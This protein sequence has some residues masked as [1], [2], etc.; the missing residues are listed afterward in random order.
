MRGWAH[1]GV[2]HSGAADR[3]AYAL[4]NRLVGNP[5]GA[6]ALECTFG[7]LVFRVGADLRGRHCRRTVPDRRDGRADPRPSATRG[8]SR[9]RRRLLSAR[10]LK[11]CAPTWRFGVASPSNP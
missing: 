4:A 9:R 8:R 7:G 3:G 2:G 6:A 11:D 1:L 10:P 5:M